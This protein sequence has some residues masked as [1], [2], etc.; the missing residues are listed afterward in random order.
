MG[1]LLKHAHARFQAIQHEALSPLGLNGRTLA[2][3]VEAADDAPV[4]QQRIGE[5]LGVDRTTMV[6]LIDSLE[7]AGFVQRR[8]DP[9]DRRGRL[10]LLTPAGEKVLADG[11]EASERVETA[12]LEPLEPFQRESFRSMAAQLV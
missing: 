1:Y 12:F 7:A 11:L 6:A 3:L 9:N 2:V 5:R 8:S 4:L 10:V